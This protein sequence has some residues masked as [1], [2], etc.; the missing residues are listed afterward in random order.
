MKKLSEKDS[1]FEDNSK[2][3]QLV[4]E[5]NKGFN[6]KIVVLWALLG[7]G[8]V[9][10]LADNDAGG[11]IS[12]ALTGTQLGI[13][14]IIP[15]TL[16]LAVIT[17]TVQEMSMRLGV[18]AKEG[19]T[20]LVRKHYGKGWMIYH[21]VAL[22]LENLITLLT[23]FIGMS[24]GLVI[25]GLPL[26]VS[27]LISLTLVLS[28]TIFAGYWVKE[29]LS[30]LIGLFNIGFIAIAFI[31]RPSF[32]HFT[33]A[34][35]NFSIPKGSDNIVLYVI[36]LIGNAVA[37]WMIFY[38]NSAYIDKGVTSK[39]IRLGRYDTLIGSIF[40]VL[41]AACVI[42][43][44]ACLFNKIPNLTEAGPAEIIYGLNSVLGFIPSMIFALA[45]FNA[46]LLASITVGLSSAWSV[47]EAFGWK[48]S[49]NNKVSEAPK[50]YAVYFISV[51]IAAIGVLIPNLPLNLISI[52]AQ[53]L[54][55][56]LMAPILI[57]LALLTSN[58]K[59][60]GKHKNST[61]TNI[62]AW[63]TVIL[64]IGIGIV[65]MFNIILGIG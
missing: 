2:F 28:I 37:P 43:I 31:T 36:A 56:I 65:T 33:S 51:I 15:L 34:F 49:L 58:E 42:I 52:I 21:I 60:M 18:V 59:I 57:F 30:L 24:A 5:P 11:I 63:I 45:L 14:F 1:L 25:L 20:K 9:A 13:S 23:E 62:R 27:V 22:L 53:I 50:F 6:K 32:A 44:G 16:C 19:Y 12:Y 3:N 10:A 47:A 64:L 7:P 48:K 54:G 29:R 26:W 39:N 61:S 41:I 8:I 4:E 38:Q 46:G 17:Y 35:L 40:Q 55:G